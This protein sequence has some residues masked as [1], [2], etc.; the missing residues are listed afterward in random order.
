MKNTERGFTLI[1]IILAIA[2]LALTSGLI[3]RLFIAGADVNAKARDIDAASQ[4]AVS[5]IERIKAL[6]SPEGLAEASLPRVYDADWR[7]TDTDGRFRLTV[8]VLSEE[9]PGGT[10]ARIT[11]AVSGADG[12]DPLVLYSAAKYFPNQRG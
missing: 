12:G 8:A 4:A 5:A 1:E 11:A 6:D 2:A 9:R 3:A 7:E 10:M